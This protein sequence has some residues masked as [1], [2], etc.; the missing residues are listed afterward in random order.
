MYP[1]YDASH[2]CQWYYLSRQEPEDVLLFK[3]FDSKEDSIKC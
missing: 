1:L 3:S 2:T